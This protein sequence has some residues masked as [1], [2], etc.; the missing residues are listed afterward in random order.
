MATRKRGHFYFAVYWVFVFTVNG[1]IKISKISGE[2]T[3][4]KFYK[5]LLVFRDEFG[6][7]KYVKSPVMNT[8]YFATEGDSKIKLTSKDT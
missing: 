5:K 3:N 6:R 7:V 2:N 4:M 8:F 1:K